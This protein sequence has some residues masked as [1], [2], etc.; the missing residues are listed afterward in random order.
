MKYPINDLSFPDCDVRSMFIDHA[1]KVAIFDMDGAWCGGRIK[2]GQFAIYN[3]LM[4]HQRRYL[5]S[6]IWVDIPSGHEETLKDILEL[7]VEGYNG[8]QNLDHRLSYS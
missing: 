2:A 7:L 5:V 3:W 1:A 4:W 8:P 6:K